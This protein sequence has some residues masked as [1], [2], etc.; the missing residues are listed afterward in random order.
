MRAIPRTTI[1]T[2]YFWI[3]QRPRGSA[4]RAVATNCAVWFASFVDVTVKGICSTEPRSTP[5]GA[6]TRNC[7]LDSASG[8]TRARAASTGRTEVEFD[9]RTAVHPE[10]R[11]VLNR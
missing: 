3:P 8:A 2:L 4:T 6:T 10:G 7:R 9:T 1:H 5:D 11:A